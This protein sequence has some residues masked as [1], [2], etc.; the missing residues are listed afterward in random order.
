MADIDLIERF[1]KADK[2]KYLS[3]DKRGG[4]LKKGL[5]VLLIAKDELHEDMLTAEQIAAILLKVQGVSCKAISITRAFSKA[6]KKVH[7]HKDIWPIRY[8]IMEL[9]R[10]YLRSSS[11]E[12]SVEV[13]LFEPGKPFSGRSKLLKD[14]LAKLKGELRIVDPYCDVETLYLLQEVKN[15]KVRFLTKKANL[16][17]K[18]KRFFKAL[19]QFQKEFPNREFK[20]YPDKD[21]HDRY[22]ISSG[23]L[24]I[25]GYSLKNWGNKESIAIVLHKDVSPNIFDAL[26]K[27]FEEKWSKAVIIP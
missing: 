22:I 4:Y 16:R 14:V 3:F 7:P 27:N 12:G 23:G 13:F 10:E 25:L 18:E 5:W 9:G 17:D 1:R 11:K 24:V 19:S 15:T 6:A 2:T 26:S 8:E 21:L 20:D